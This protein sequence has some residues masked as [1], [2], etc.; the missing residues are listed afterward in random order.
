MLHWNL[1][2]LMLHLNLIEHWNLIELMLHLNLIEL[3]LH[4]NLI[5]LVSLHWTR[6]KECVTIGVHFEVAPPFAQYMYISMGM[7]L[8]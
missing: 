2:E 8:G 5:E 1:I 7:R 6:E 3:M 4:W